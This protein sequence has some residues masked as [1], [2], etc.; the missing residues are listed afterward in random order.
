[1]QTTGE[2]LVMDELRQ[3]YQLF[4]HVSD[5]AGLPWSNKARSVGQALANQKCDISTLIAVLGDK[6]SDEF[7]FET[8]S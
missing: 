5:K 7:Y 8:L 4:R 6:K 1:M 2:D 3:L